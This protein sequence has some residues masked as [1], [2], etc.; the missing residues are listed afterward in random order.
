MPKDAPKTTA[1]LVLDGVPARV[2]A[3]WVRPL[4]VQRDPKMAALLVL[5]LA[6]S[7]YQKVPQRQPLVLTSLGC[8][9][10]YSDQIKK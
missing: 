9:L 7:I 10:L 5:F 8:L 4:D 6:T 2:G 3:G 1:G